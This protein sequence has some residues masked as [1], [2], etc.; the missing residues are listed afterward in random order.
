MRN[1]CSKNTFPSPEESSAGHHSHRDVLHSDKQGGGV[2]G[3]PDLNNGKH[4][5]YHPI[6]YFKRH[7]QPYS[8]LVLGC[9]C[10]TLA[11]VFGA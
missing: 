7:T 11:Q 2:G 9:D 8:L 1:S 10:S 4:K 6:I 5:K 3:T